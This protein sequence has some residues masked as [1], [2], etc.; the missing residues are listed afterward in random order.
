MR[1]P[2]HDPNKLLLHN[3]GNIP[4]QREVYKDNTK[5]MIRNKLYT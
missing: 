1:D 3:N 5:A 4:R 2:M